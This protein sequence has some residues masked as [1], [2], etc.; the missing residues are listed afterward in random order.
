MLSHKIETVG[1]RVY[2]LSGST[3]HQSFVP[4]TGTQRIDSM[5]SFNYFEPTDD[6]TGVRNIY[7]TQTNAKA[8]QSQLQNPARAGILNKL[9][10]L[11]EKR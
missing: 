3:T 2:L 10:D 9:R 11:L 1:N 6:D 4:L 7:I 8:L 5:F